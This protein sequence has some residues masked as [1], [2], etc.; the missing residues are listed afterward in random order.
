MKVKQVIKILIYNPTLYVALVVGGLIGGAF[1]ALTGFFSG[2]FLGQDFKICSRC[3]S[4]IFGYNIQIVDMNTI[5]GAAAG[6]IIG[7][8]AGGIV[9]A[10][11][12][13]FHVFRNRALPIQLSN[14]TLL[15]VLTF[16]LLIA[17]ELGLGML[18]GAIIGASI[19]RSIGSFAGACMGFMIMFVLT[20]IQTN[21]Q[22]REI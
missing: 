4:I 9:V 12:T 15:P 10:L 2:I 6:L 3:S 20:I 7:A 11:G 19:Y 21:N 5:A 18:I 17:I 8:A 13:G 1:G 16:C 22:K 14:I